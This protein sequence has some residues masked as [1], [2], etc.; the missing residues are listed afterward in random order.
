MCF[1]YVTLIHRSHSCLRLSALNVINFLVFWF[2]LIFYNFF[3]CSFTSALRSPCY[4]CRSIRFFY[5]FDSIEWKW[6]FAKSIDLHFSLCDV[7]S[8]PYKATVSSTNDLHLYHGPPSSPPPLLDS[9]LP[10]TSVNMQ[11][12][13]TRYGLYTVY[14]QYSIR[15]KSNR[16]ICWQTRR[17]SAFMAASRILFRRILNSQ[18]ATTRHNLPKW[19]AVN[20]FSSV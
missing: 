12:T 5:P 15:L 1:V 4:C 9:F 8:L 19:D 2:L 16:Y 20:N 14:E 10:D 11:S 18:S 17:A 13:I 7:H 6:I 3:L